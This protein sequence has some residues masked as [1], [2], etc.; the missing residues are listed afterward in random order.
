MHRKDNQFVFLR[1]GTVF[2]IF[3]LS[4]KSLNWIFAVCFFRN[5]AVCKMLKLKEIFFKCLYYFLYTQYGLPIKIWDGICN[6]M[7]TKYDNRIE[8]VLFSSIF[9]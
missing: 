2:I 5:L 4:V 7:Q 1:N 9:S 8:T 6:T 3:F